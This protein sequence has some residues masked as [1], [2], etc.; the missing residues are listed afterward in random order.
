MAVRTSRSG[1]ASE[2]AFSAASDG[3]GGTG[4][5]IGVAATRS[6]GAAGIT[7]EAPRFTTET[8]SIE[9]AERVEDSP[10]RAAVMAARVELS[11]LGPTEA[12]EGSGALTEARP[13]A[14]PPASQPDHLT[15]IP[16]L[17]EDT[18]RPLD[19]AEY[20]RARSAVTLRA[21][22]PEA[23]RR[24]EAPASVVEAHAVAEGDFTAVV[25][26]GK[27]DRETLKWR[28]VICG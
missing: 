7:P 16:R 27:T 3:A 25:D 15:E 6:T 4:D 20:G 17:H 8:L 5:T 2:S 14:L 24:A 13:G 1:L 12:Q 11:R 21:G 10:A 26:I 9:A 18:R 22:R 28:K 19:K 23:F